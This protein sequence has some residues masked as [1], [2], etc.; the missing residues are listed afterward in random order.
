MCKSSNLKSRKGFTLIEVIVVVAITAILASVLIVY[1]R[2]SEQQILLNVEKAKIAQTILRLKSLALSGYTKPP[3]NPPTCSYGFT[4]DYATDTET[5][6]LFE[7]NP[8]EGCDNILQIVSLD[9]SSNFFREIE[10]STLDKKLDFDTGPDRVGYFIYI[11]PDPDILLFKE[12][13]FTYFA[14][15]LEIYLKTQDN[16]LRTK[17]TI[18]NVTGQLS[19]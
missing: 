15:P 9:T 13:K 10:S 12:D 11:P 19:F 8:P 17:I 5:Y 4:V 18:N 2:R 1:S 6:S 3:T 16:S 14:G 7:Y